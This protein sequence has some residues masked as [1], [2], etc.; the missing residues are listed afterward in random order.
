MEL[1][2][3]VQE[4]VGGSGRDSLL[5]ESVYSSREVRE[6]KKKLEQSI[7]QLENEMDQHSEKYRQ[8]LQKGADVDEMRRRQYAQKAKFEK[9]KYKV[10]KKKHEAQSIK[11]GTVISIEGAREITEM[12]DDDEEFTNVGAIM[13]D[14]INAQEVQADIM[15]QMARFGLD[16]EDMKQVQDALDVEILDDELEEGASEELEV[17]EEMAAGEVSR[18]Q[19]DI[20]EEVGIES[21]DLDVRSDIDEEV[22]IPDV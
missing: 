7:K 10:K 4:K 17:I 14:D 5:D 20:D 8:L 9:K 6:D 15:D 19:I 2:N 12:Q 3:W 13:Q 22:E 16:I 11:L 21:D 1:R 18:E